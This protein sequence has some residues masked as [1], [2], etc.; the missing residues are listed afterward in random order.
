MACLMAPDGYGLWRL[1]RSHW[2]GET[3]TTDVW[4]GEPWDSKSKDANM[5]SNSDMMVE[6]RETVAASAFARHCETMPSLESIT[7][8]NVAWSSWLQAI[9]ENRS[10]CIMI[11]LANG[12]AGESVELL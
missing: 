3:T 4:V 2:V 7:S 10:S 5:S 9:V 12:I 11:G 1:S 6:V 8:E